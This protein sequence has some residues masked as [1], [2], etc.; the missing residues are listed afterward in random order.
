[1]TSAL[2]GALSYVWMFCS[3]LTYPW[4]SAAGAAGQSGAF[5][6]YGAFGLTAALL[7]ATLLPE[8]RYEAGADRDGGGEDGGD[9]HPDLCVEGRGMHK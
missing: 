8:T 9:S 7:G 3:S 5:L 1:M 2:T 6:L 4:I